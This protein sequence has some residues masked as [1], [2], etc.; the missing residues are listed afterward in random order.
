MYL[1][2]ETHPL[3][4]SDLVSGKRLFKMSASEIANDSK[5]NT[6]LSDDDE[7]IDY[8]STGSDLL[9]LKKIIEIIE[10]SNSDN[11]AREAATKISNVVKE[12]DKKRRD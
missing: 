7:L 4:F 3:N 5:E 12:Y 10:R 6:D 11:E 1:I 9:L 2:D 8:S